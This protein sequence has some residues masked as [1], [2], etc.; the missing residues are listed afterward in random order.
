MEIDIV[1]DELK[2]SIKPARRNSIYGTTGRVFLM[3]TAHSYG[4]ELD[5]SGRLIDKDGRV[6]PKADPLYEQIISRAQTQAETESSIGEE[7]LNG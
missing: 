1:T 2:E 7:I 4:C 6:L 5:S 3:A